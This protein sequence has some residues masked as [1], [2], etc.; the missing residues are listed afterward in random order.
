MKQ[1]WRSATAVTLILGCITVNQTAVAQ[2]A[3]PEIIHD[4]EYS[5]LATQHG[6]QWSAED[7]DINRKLAELRRKYGTPPN[8]IH[9]MWDDTAVGEVGIPAI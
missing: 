6:E 2:R 3:K 8:I 9:I 7:Q 5:I 4:A 1:G